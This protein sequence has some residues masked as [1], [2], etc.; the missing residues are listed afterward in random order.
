[1]APQVAFPIESASTMQRPALPSDAP[2]R[3]HAPRPW[4]AATAAL[5]AALVWA[6]PGAPSL[7]Q[8]QAGTPQA[9]D[10]PTSSTGQDGMAG[11][12]ATEGIEGNPAAA[13]SPA[14]PT[15][16]RETTPTAVSVVAVESAPWTRVV[17][18]YGAV[19][20]AQAV[21]VVAQGGGGTLLAYLVD[22]GQRV[23]QGSPIARLDD[24]DAAIALAQ[25][26]AALDQARASLDEQRALQAREQALAGVATTQ[27]ALDNRVFAVAR[28]QAAVDQAQAALDQA[29]LGIARATPVAPVD[30]VV[31]DTPA[32]LGATVGNGAVLAVVAA[33]GQAAWNGALRAEDAARLRVGQQARMAWNG[34]AWQGTVD[35]VGPGVDANGLTA[36][37]LLMEPM[38]GMSPR[39]QDAPSARPVLLGGTATAF[40]ELPDGEGTAVPTSA[41]VYRSGTP[42]VAV[43]DG[44]TV[45]FA[46]VSIQAIGPDTVLV[47]GLSEGQQV[48]TSG[49]GFLGEGEGV[50][51]V[52]R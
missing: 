43:V 3:A 25:A 19:A 28:A 33:Q 30:G 42:W 47:D 2:R 35:R 31:L 1:M 13:P 32:I 38:E 10:T 11:T 40:F 20:P 41:L 17:E 23:T 26:Q 44:G 48:V 4:G 51:V 24:G 49:A 36:V 29:A 5:L 52:S 39:P 14:D 34:D 7:A 18:A 22:P 6:L 8:D 50:Q 21:E 37:R 15:P 45:R 9:Q 16:S 27:A 46:P 12:K